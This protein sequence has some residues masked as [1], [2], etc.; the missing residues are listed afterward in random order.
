[1]SNID[2]YWI[3]G[4]MLSGVV[5]LYSHNLAIFTLIAL[6][7]FLIFQKEWKKL[8]HMFCGRV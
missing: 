4:L 3:G 1:M 8:L 6:D 7:I 5:A 2:N